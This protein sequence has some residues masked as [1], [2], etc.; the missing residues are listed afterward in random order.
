MKV[1]AYTCRPREQSLSNEFYWL[2]IGTKWFILFEG[3]KYSL[4]SSSLLCIC[5]CVTW[6]IIA[7]CK[8]YFFDWIIFEP[9]FLFLHIGEPC[10]ATS[11]MSLQWS[12]VFKLHHSNCNVWC[13][14]INDVCYVLSVTVCVHWFC[15]C[16]VTKSVQNLLFIII[17]EYV[18]YYHTS[19][20]LWLNFFE[21]TVVHNGAFL[22]WW[23]L[24]YW[25]FMHSWICK[26][27]LHHSVNPVHISSVVWS[28]WI[29]NV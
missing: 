28:P 15:Q 4:F 26:L 24:L 13:G 3:M 20:C 17:G 29:R 23:E 5:N 14:D 8:C 9:V 10:I 25:S 16:I 22:K 27:L 6:W 18:K 1:N 21:S 7:T 2:C 11:K 12:V 19:K